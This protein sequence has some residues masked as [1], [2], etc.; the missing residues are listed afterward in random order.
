MAKLPSIEGTACNSF[1]KIFGGS[2]GNTQ[3]YQIDVYNDYLAMAGM[4]ED[5]QLT[6]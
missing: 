1:P 6:G 5:T 3:L 2:N 4:S